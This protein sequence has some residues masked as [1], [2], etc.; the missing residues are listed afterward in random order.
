MELAAK[1]RASGVGAILSSGSRGLRGQLRQ[2]NALGIPYAA[3][4]GEDEIQRGEVMVR[5]MLNSTQETRL[6]ETFLEGAARQ[7][8]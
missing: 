4:L 5:D 6:M 7:H 8:G 3:I 1:L 2:A